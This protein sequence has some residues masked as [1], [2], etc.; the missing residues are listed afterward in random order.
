MRWMRMTDRHDI[1]PLLVNQEMHRQLARRPSI[2]KWLPRCV[3]YRKRILRHAAFANHGRRGDDPPVVKTHAH[4][5][6]R[7]DDIT[8]LIQEPAY[9]YDFTPCGLFVHN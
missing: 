4:I 5:A 3:G 2:T 7:R 6:V 8:A 9:V 1:R